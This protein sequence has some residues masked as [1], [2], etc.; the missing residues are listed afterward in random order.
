MLSAAFT[1]GPGV[2][3]IGSVFHIKYDSED[4]LTVNDNKGVGA[5]AGLRLSF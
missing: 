1:M 4:N 5:V 2:D 3:L